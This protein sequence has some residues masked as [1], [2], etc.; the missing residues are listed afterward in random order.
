MSDEQEPQTCKELNKAMA[1]AAISLVGWIQDLDE[2]ERTTPGAEGW[3]VKDHVAHLDIWL[4]GMVALLRHEDRVAAMG[5]DA[6]DFESGDFER[7]NATIYARHRDKS[8]DEVWGDYM[9]TLDAFNETL[10]DLDDAD[11][12]RPYASFLPDAAEDDG[13]GAPIVGWIVGN[14]YHHINEHLPWMQAIVAGQSG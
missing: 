11:L 7:M 8:W 1:M 13:D 9:A 5:V 4:R 10:T 6:A 2:D 3:S 12:Q 14:S